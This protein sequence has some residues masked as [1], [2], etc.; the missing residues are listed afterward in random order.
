M[1]WWV[2][3]SLLLTH[4]V[5][6]FD[7]Q[8]ELL[9]VADADELDVEVGL[10]VALV[11]RRGDKLAELVAQRLDVF[12]A[13]GG[14]HVQRQTLLHR[15]T[16][17]DVLD[18][19]RVGD[20]VGNLHGLV[21]VHAAEDGVHQADTFH[22]ELDL[23]DVDSVTNIVPG[24]FSKLLSEEAQDAYGCLTNRKMQQLRNSVTVPNTVSFA[25]VRMATKW[26]YLL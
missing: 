23:S 22:N 16:T 21:G 26:P 9:H 17:A 25:N 8:L 15:R 4:L 24:W 5:L 13:G 1:H 19:E 12:G 18:P 11:L 14:C 2:S 6:D 3:R 10:E 20:G 7:P